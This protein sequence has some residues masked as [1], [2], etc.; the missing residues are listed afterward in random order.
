MSKIWE[1]QRFSKNP[2]SMRRSVLQIFIFTSQGLS[3]LVVERILFITRRFIATYCSC[4]LPNENVTPTAAI[5]PIQV[6]VWLGSGERQI[7]DN[8]FSDE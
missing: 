5:S 7:R 1:F 4:I 8:C 3:P 2:K 6:G